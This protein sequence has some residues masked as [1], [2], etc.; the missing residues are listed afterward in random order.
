MVTI[1][2]DNLTVVQ[3]QQGELECLVT[4]NPA[5]VSVSWFQHQQELDIDGEK[6]SVSQSD[7]GSHLL[8]ISNST[9]SHSGD[10]SC[11]AENDLGTGSSENL[12]RIDVLC[13]Y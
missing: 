3:G 6:Y 9:S 11:S 7:S 5:N 10:F 8:L 13:E 1:S 12:A 2:P 4:S